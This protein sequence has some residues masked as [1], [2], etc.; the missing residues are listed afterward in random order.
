MPK[1]TIT[2]PYVD[3]NTF[4]MGNPTPES[5]LKVHK[6]KNFF[7]LR[8]DFLTFLCLVMPNYNLLEKILFIGPILGKL[9]SFPTYSVYTK[10]GFSSSQVK[11]IFQKNS[12]MTPLT[13][14]LTGVG[15]FGPSLTY[16]E[17]ALKMLKIRY[18]QKIGI[19]QAGSQASFEIRTV[20]ILDLICLLLIFL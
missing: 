12:N 5:T 15:P 20:P 4:T 11:K 19:P 8:F 9:R 10:R 2:S 1:L 6:H 3:S 16:M 13:L 14:S 17:F 18:R 7:R